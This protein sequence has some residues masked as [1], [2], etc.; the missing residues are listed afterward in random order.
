MRKQKED[1]GEGRMSR[2][3]KPKEPN[4][5]SS[6]NQPKPSSKPAQ[7]TTPMDDK[8]SRPSLVERASR[9][10]LEE[11]DHTKMSRDISSPTLS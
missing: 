2:V 1:R 5:T 9:R 11:D 4:E 3:R 10:F 8:K 7:K 6:Q